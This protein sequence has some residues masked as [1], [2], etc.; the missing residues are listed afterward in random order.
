MISKDKLSGLTNSEKAKKIIKSVT[1]K[2]NFNDLTDFEKSNVLWLIANENIEV[3]IF[4]YAGYNILKLEFFV[5]EYVYDVKA[6]EKY[7]AFKDFETFYEYVY[8][9]IYNK[10]TCFYGYEFTNEEIEK[11]NLEI[12]KLNFDSFIDDDINKSSII[13][14]YKKKKKEALESK[15]YSV[16]HKEFADE[17]SKSEAT[18]NYFKRLNIDS[19]K[20]PEQTYNFLKLF[21]AHATISDEDTLRYL[22]LYFGEDFA[23]EFAASY[24][25]ENWSERI[26][27]DIKR[28]L[29]TIFI[30]LKNA[31][32]VEYFPYYDDERGLFIVKFSYYQGEEKV[33]EIKDYF[34]TFEEMADY[35]NGDLTS[36]DLKD[37]FIEISDLKKYKIG[38]NTILPFGEPGE[39]ILKKY[40]KDGKFIVEQILFNKAKT[41]FYKKENKF[42]MICD[43]IHFLKNDLSNSDLIMC[44]GVGNLKK[45]EGLKLDGVLARKEDLLKLD[46]TSISL[47]LVENKK[48]NYIEVI[49]RNE[50][51]VLNNEIELAHEIEEKEALIGYISDLHLGHRFD[52]NKIS[53]FSDA[54]FYIRDFNSR[55]HNKYFEIRREHQIFDNEELLLIAGDVT[56]NINLYKMFFNEL[57]VSEIKTFVTLGNHELWPFEGKSIEEITEEYRKILDKKG[58]KLVQNNLFYITSSGVREIRT[59]ELINISDNELSL[60]TREAKIIIFGGIGFSGRNEVLNANGG[61]YQNVITRE[62]EIEESKK[63]NELFNK[64]KRSLKNK[65]VIVLTHMPIKDWCED[66]SDLGNFRYVNGH[67]HFNYFNRDKHIYA[68]NQIGYEGK[69]LLLKYFSIN[70]NYHW[71]DSFN[72]GIYEISSYDY[73]KFYRGINYLMKM[74]HEN[75]KYFM[76]KKNNFYMFF[77]S[78]KEQLYILEGAAIRKVNKSLNYYFKNLELYVKNVEKL[79]FNTNQYLTSI[80]N[81]VKKVGGDGSIHG[82]I[83]DIDYYNHIFFDVLNNKLLFYFA[84]SIIDKYFYENYVSLLKCRLPLL[85]GNFLK[86]ISDKDNK[87]ELALYNSLTISDSN[88]YEASTEMY[89]YSKFIKSLQNVSNVHVIRKWSE[90]ILNLN[91]NE[92]IKRLVK[93]EFI[94]TGNTEK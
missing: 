70:E 64:V 62:Q 14:Q 22:W 43:F 9:D 27:R 10:N 47:P 1:H 5:V 51:S 31:T 78:Y 91:D 79:L 20:Y 83:V 86:T 24:Y 11:F 82:L 16:G 39:V 52:A 88:I 72:D 30:N 93:N 38:K 61:V 4:K 92:F 77:A 2:A 81:E 50:L 23:Q 33:D 37:S 40:Y 84:T 53:N 54:I 18:K 3:R 34:F 46:F 60:K 56:D 12:S 55:M 41:S 19:S 49:N 85:Y 65:N 44:E 87:N 25:N 6:I 26:N 57:D 67:N 28:E 42:D 8:H 36:A 73:I 74:T 45:I 59:E 90:D 94:E 13:K 48:L 66:D 68:D 69:N 71:F 80:S 29:K 15:N 32:K 63:F 76:I 89:K 35:L 75:D 7:Y 21:V 17:L 58:V